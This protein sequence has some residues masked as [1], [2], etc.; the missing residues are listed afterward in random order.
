SFTI[1]VLA[2]FAVLVYQFKSF[3]QPFII[4]ST[5]PLAIVGSVIAL[6]LSGNNI[7]FTA[8][9]GLTSLAGIVINNAIIL[10]D[11]ANRRRAEGDS[12]E[13]ALIFAGEIRF[14]PIV[15]T[16]A[17]T[18]GGLLPLTLFGG[19]MWNPMGWAIIGGLIT[20]T[21]LTLLVVPVLYELL[22]RD[23]NEA[24]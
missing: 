20:S 17:T 7:S 24:V 16:A 21:A 4:F 10:V 8:M 18:I 3:R 1:A 13:E 6:F 2:I 11:F 19:L 14:V 9:I 23:I 5:I 22:S 12:T 15:L